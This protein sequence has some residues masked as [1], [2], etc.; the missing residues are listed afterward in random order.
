[1]NK[2]SERVIQGQLYN[3]DLNRDW[4]IKRDVTNFKPLIST[5]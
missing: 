2:S 3:V 4:W 1:M 5:V